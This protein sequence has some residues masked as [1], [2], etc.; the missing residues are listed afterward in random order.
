M[1]AKLLDG[2]GVEA[3]LNVGW[4]VKRLGVVAR[5]GFAPEC[6]LVVLN[7]LDESVLMLMTRT[8]FG[9]AL[10]DFAGFSSKVIGIGE[11][12]T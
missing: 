4:T 7:V 8:T 11:K 2:V 1:L 9:S 12:N 5:P 6:E 10:D 3:I